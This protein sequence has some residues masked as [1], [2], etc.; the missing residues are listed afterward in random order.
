VTIGQVVEENLRVSRG[1][2]GRVHRRRKRQGVF[3]TWDEPEKI[4]ATVGI[5][6]A[7][8]THETHHTAPS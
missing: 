6:A 2:Y 5:Q 8:H 3:R 7:S 4:S 1:R